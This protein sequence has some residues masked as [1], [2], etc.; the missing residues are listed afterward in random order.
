MRAGKGQPK[1]TGVISAVGRYLRPNISGQSVAGD[2]VVLSHVRK[3]AGERAD[4][5]GD[6][7]LGS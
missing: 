6:R 3:N 2:I 4:A 5:D 1:V 7:D